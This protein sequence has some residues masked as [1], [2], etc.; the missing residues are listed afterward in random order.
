MKIVWLIDPS[1][2][3]LV[4]C[5]FLCATVCVPSFLH[6]SPVCLSVCVSD[7]IFVCAFTL[8]AMLLD[9]KG[10]NEWC[11]NLRAWLVIAYRT[12]GTITKFSVICFRAIAYHH[13]HHH[14]QRISSRR[15]S[16][17][18]FRAAIYAMKLSAVLPVSQSYIS[19]RKM[20]AYNELYPQTS[21]AN[22]NSCSRSIYVIARPSVCRLSV[23]NVRAPYSCDWNLR[24][25]FVWYVGHLL[26][27]K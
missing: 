25:Y 20:I 4:N 17:K 23:C 16:Y 9:T 12:N 19:Y 26:T 10:M 5:V 24:Q 6:H 7:F 18:N 2:V 15:K 3:V 1:R 22:V 8:W 14:H 13:H 21:L 11:K 27:S